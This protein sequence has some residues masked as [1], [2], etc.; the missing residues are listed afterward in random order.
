[1]SFPREASQT[2]SP[3]ASNIPKS[4]LYRFLMDFQLWLPIWVLYLRD[5]K[6]FSLTQINLLDTP[7]F[8]LIV[9][10]AVAAPCPRLPT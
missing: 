1:M 5:E 2:T 9:L 10:A 6:G 4:F 8:L 7:F 3:Y